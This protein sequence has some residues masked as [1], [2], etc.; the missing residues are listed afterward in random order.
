MGVLV[1]SLH[2]GEFGQSAKGGYGRPPTLVATSRALFLTSLY[3]LHPR[4][5]QEKATE[6]VMAATGWGQR[7]TNLEEG[8]EAAKPVAGNLD[9]VEDFYA[10]ILCF[11]Y[12][13]LPLPE[14]AGVSTYF[15]SMWDEKSNLFGPAPGQPG[16][17]KSSALLMLAAEQFG[18]LHDLHGEAAKIRQVLNQSLDA[19]G[20]WFSF[21]KEYMGGTNSIVANYYAVVLARKCGHDFQNVTGMTNFIVSLQQLD[22]SL[23]K[24]GG[25]YGD[26]SRAFIS[27]E[28]TV[29]G[30]ATLQMLSMQPLPHHTSSHA[31][32]TSDDNASDY[33]DRT[34]KDVGAVLARSLDLNALT[35]FLGKAPT[36]LKS[37]FLVHLALS[38][39]PSLLLHSFQTAISYEFECS[40]KQLQ[41]TLTGNVL[42]ADT[43][44]ACPLSEMIWSVRAGSNQIVQGT[45][46]RPTLNV[47]TFRGLPHSGLQV[48]LSASYYSGLNGAAEVKLQDD[49]DMPWNADTQNYVSR[50]LVQ[51]SAFV[52]KLKIYITAKSEVPGL[53]QISF[54]VED[55]KLI[56]YG[57]SISS[58]AEVDGK[59]VPV[60]GDVKLGSNFSVGLVL[61][62]GINGNFLQGN[63]LIKFRVLDASLL[64]MGIQWLNGTKNEDPIRFNYSLSSDALLPSGRL[65]FIIE[66]F[67]PQSG[68]VTLIVGRQKMRNLLPQVHT[69]TMLWYNLKQQMVASN[70]TIDK[71]NASLGD[72]VT[73]EMI[74]GI[75][76]ES[77]QFR[78]FTSRTAKHRRFVMEL[79]SPTGD[80]GRRIDG[81]LSAGEN[82]SK[83][84]FVRKVE[85]NLRSLGEYS[86]T[87]RFL[88]AH[89][90]GTPQILR[91][92]CGFSAP[93]E[94]VPGGICEH[95]KFNVS[96]NLRVEMIKSNPVAGGN[97]TLGSELL[98]AFKVI[99]TSTQVEVQASG[100]DAARVLLY[101][102]DVAEEICQHRII[103]GSNSVDR[104]SEISLAS[105]ASEEHVASSSSAEKE[106]RDGEFVVRWTVGPNTVFGK[107]ILR[108]KM[109]V[110]DGVDQDLLSAET[111]EGWRYEVNVGGE[112]K[113][114]ILSVYTTQIIS[115]LDPEQ[116]DLQCRH[117]SL[118]LQQDAML[119]IVRLYLSYWGVEYKYTE[120]IREHSN[121]IW[122]QMS[123][124]S[125]PIIEGARMEVSNLRVT[126]TRWLGLLRFNSSQVVVDWIAL[127]GD[128]IIASLQ[129]SFCRLLQRIQILWRSFKEYV[130]SERW[131]L[132]VI[133]FHLDSE[134]KNFTGATLLADLKY[135]S[136]LQAQWKAMPGFT[137]VPVLYEND[138][139][140]QL[141]SAD[142]NCQV[143]SVSNRTVEDDECMISICRDRNGQYR[144]N[145]RRLVDLQAEMLQ[146]ERIRKKR[147]D[148]DLLALRRGLPVIETEASQFDLFNVQEQVEDKVNPIFYICIALIYMF[149]SFALLRTIVSLGSMA[150]FKSSQRSSHKVGKHKKKNRA[151]RTHSPP[152]ERTTGLAQTEGTEETQTN[153]QVQAGPVDMELSSEQI[154]NDELYYANDM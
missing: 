89:Y 43:L 151:R 97:I 109:Q 13:N 54:S 134:S 64:T 121:K 21:P 26:Q 47:S 147:D 150:S 96:A 48:K 142:R 129:E 6:F 87:F 119:Y 66:I 130:S 116:N 83:Y 91:N 34:S 58:Q 68:Q 133:N 28:T 71:R 143:C 154:E 107:L 61:F 56:G 11:Q 3:G 113:G 41:Q 108:L 126:A 101:I 20:S 2:S 38:S 137:E 104:A 93:D 67:D 115:T 127:R 112:V 90:A 70:I 44:S 145:I 135:R 16:D 92:L 99:E 118:S 7:A 72:T 50:E 53:G 14:L 100:E 46:I 144:V 17:V 79:I 76:T 73:V 12:L 60:G 86:V 114:T 122:A 128:Q 77:D 98:L 29:Y 117:L 30:V 51:T 85:T 49:V 106:R 78:P 136:T 65:H 8:E 84:T 1:E 4:I 75:I 57:L 42:H 32:Q 63:F 139:N 39:V 110:V 36:D 141:F 125:V 80:V 5:N 153:S 111:E 24:Y 31:N 69:N 9:T 81:V 10:A 103:A 102:F 124:M 18:K 152:S 74:P 40:D 149:G 33:S 27:L 45:A 138:G 37:A 120:S 62:N 23:T 94:E 131:A 123:P 105:N 15:R 19:S 35:C 59:Q 55:T 52:G 22:K 25:L 95:L 140:Y 82:I 88:S 148:A 132:F 146:V